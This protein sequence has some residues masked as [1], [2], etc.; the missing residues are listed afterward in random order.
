MSTSQT[1]I[2]RALRGFVLG[3]AVLALTSPAFAQKAGPHRPRTDRAVD[4]A[5]RNGTEIPV[6]VRYTDAAAAERVKKPKGGKREVRR[7]L[8]AAGALSLKVNARALRELLEDEAADVL[9]VSYDAPVA[10]QQLLGL[11]LLQP[12]AVSIEASGSAAARTRYGVNGA[13]VTVAVI[14]SGVKPHTDLPT[15][16][17]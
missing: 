2:T 16:R 5:L 4:D 15:S 6:I 10:G 8:K 13:G 3:T 17:I 9:S 12:T 7:H 14:D 1:S 11:N